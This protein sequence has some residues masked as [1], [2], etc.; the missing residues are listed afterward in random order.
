[1]TMPMQGADAARVKRQRADQAVSLALESRWEEA[2]T[3]NRQ[4]LDQLPNDVDTWN[5]LGKALLELG[6]YRDSREAYQKSLE[7]DPVNTIAKRNLDRLA[8]VKDEEAPRGE[9]GG[10]VAQDLFIEEMGKSGTTVLSGVAPEILSRLVAG[11]EVYLKPDGTVLN[12]ENG[13][14]EMIGTV[15]PK[16]GLRL[17]NLMQGG[18][19]YAAAVKSVGTNGAEIIIKETFRDPSQKRLSFPATSIEGVRAYTRESLLRYDTDEEEEEPE[20]EVENEDWDTEAEDVTDT[21]EVSL[22]SFKE[23]IEGHE[24]EEDDL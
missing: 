10:K 2:V 17:T 9:I 14:G 12:V 4:I 21:A 11:D 20:E 15:E 5:R 22:S 23:T 1:M 13:Q 19:R 6:R 3:L 16:L 24:D 7:L 8:N 18:N